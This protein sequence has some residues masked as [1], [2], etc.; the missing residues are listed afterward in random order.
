MSLSPDGSPFRLRIS[1]YAKTYIRERATELMNCT[2]LAYRP[3]TEY[4]PVTR[5]NTSTLGVLVYDGPARVW[6]VPGAAQVVIGDEQLTI[7]QSFLSVPWATPSF[8]L[9]T[10]ILVTAADDDDLVGRSLNIESSVRGG[11]LRASRMFQV[12]ISTSKRDSW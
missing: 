1:S 6:E 9:D 10:M 3:G 5:R 8:T 12:S 7:S 4:D 11:G 2:V